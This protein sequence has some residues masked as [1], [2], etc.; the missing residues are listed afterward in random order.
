MSEY[1]ADVILYDEV[2]SPYS[3]TTIEQAGMGGSEFQ[4]ILLLEQ[5]SEQG[6]NVICLNNTRQE[7][8]VK[9]VLYLPND[10]VKKHSFKCRNLIIHRYSQPPAIK[11]IKAFMWATDLNGPHNLHFYDLFEEKKLNL[12][13][14][15][16]FQSNLFPKNWNKHV[17]Y[18]MIPDWVYDYKIPEK[19]KNFIYASSIMKG[20]G[21]TLEYWKFLKLKNL[22]KDKTLKVCLPGYDNPQNS[23]ADE[24][25]NIEYLGTL[26]FRK[27]V[28]TIADCE[29]MFYVNT[30]P[31]TFGISIVLAEALKTTPYV[32]GINGL[33]SL[34]ELLNSQTLTNDMG[35]FINY[36]KNYKYTE[37]KSRIFKAEMV[38]KHWKK[39][40]V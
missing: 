27:V 19:K 30:M 29:G 31:E 39:I 24:N 23:L 14:L 32:F 1:F 26:P 11:C 8:F 9:G 21:P 38:M 20:F 17:I 7:H 10:Y 2:G 16:E 6:K 35:I 3:G 28:E 12:I 40:L 5:L 4:A 37:S 13:S 36:F 22:L 34:S 33:G 25:F 18:Y 15:S